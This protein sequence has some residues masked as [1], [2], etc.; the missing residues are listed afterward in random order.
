MIISVSR[1]D[2][3]SALKKKI[4][5]KN[6]IKVVYHGL[7]NEEIK[8]IQSSNKTKNSIGLSNENIVVGT[9]AHFYK[10]KGLEY[11]VNA[12]EFIVKEVKNVKFVII[13]DGILEKEIKSLII[14]K[15]LN[16][17]VLMLGYRQDAVEIM[18][19]FDIFVMS[20][21][22][23]GFPFILLEAMAAGKAIVATKVG[24]IPEMIED[25]KEGILVNSGDVKALSEAILGLINNKTL[26]DTLAKNA[27]E[28]IEKRFLS[29]DMINNT[30]K[31]YNELIL[32]KCGGS[33]AA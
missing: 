21:I 13:G 2:L 19:I 33:Y 23:E 6:K 1:M 27:R 20:S 26:A 5:S 29:Q 7:E 28:K 30:E 3:N 25:R 4:I 24:G 32:K 17:N 31:L 10:T 12:A 8:K 9:I 14:S 18:K 11:L 15:D 16:E 22:K